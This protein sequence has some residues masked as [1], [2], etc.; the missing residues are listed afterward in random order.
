MILET[1]D[2]EYIDCNL[3][4]SKSH[5]LFLPANTDFSQIS[6]NALACTSIHHS[7][8]GPIVRCNNCGLIFANPRPSPQKIIEIYSQVEDHVYLAEEEGRVATFKN[9]LA[10]IS[11][12]KR[13]GKLLDVE[14]HVGTFLDIAKD[15]G[16]EVYG[17]EPSKWAAE[18]CRNKR[19]IEVQECG[20]SEANLEDSSFEVITM[21][22]VIEHLTDPYKELR[23]ANSLLR[24]DG[25]LAITT[26]NVDS[27]FAKVLG[28]HYPWYMLM[29]L[30]Y[31][32][33]DTME[34]ILGKS[35]FRILE[36]K[37]HIRV[38]SLRYLFSKIKA[39]SPAA[40]RAAHTVAHLLKIHD[41]KVP[42]NFGDIMTVIARKI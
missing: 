18:Y 30:Y 8:H 13:K 4:G 12:Y 39:Y 40:Y 33:P 32:T 19:N 37:H 21:W 27:V 22:D 17:L 29:H 26:M 35:G 10:E 15:Y 24:D 6:A 34:K 1:S 2:L 7:K 41:L 28:K 3:C 36:I 14:C 25:I 38:V 31:F 5:S 11:R 23:R 9:N 16:Y 20:L 42:L